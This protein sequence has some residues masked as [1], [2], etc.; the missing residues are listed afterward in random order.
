M[1]RTDDVRRISYATNLARYYGTTGE[2]QSTDP[3]ELCP[4]TEIR[5][6]GAE[7]SICLLSEDKISEMKEAPIVLGMGS[8][9]DRARLMRSTNLVEKKGYPALRLTP[10]LVTLP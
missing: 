5:V 1:P 8:K 3:E 9:E 10:W 6:E 4:V 7:D 2:T